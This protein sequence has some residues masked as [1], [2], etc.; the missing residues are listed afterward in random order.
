M[1][2]TVWTMITRPAS[3]ERPA[4]REVRWFAVSCMRQSIRN[5]TRSRQDLAWRLRLLGYKRFHFDGR[6]HLS[7]WRTV[8]G[9]PAHDGHVELRRKRADVLRAR[10]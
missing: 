6:P 1:A 2:G 4:P 8:L 10:T 7:P 3:K 5:A 9:L